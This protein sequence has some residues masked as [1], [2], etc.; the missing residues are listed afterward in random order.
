MTDQLASAEATQNPH[1]YAIFVDGEPKEH[2]ADR[3]HY[4]RI[5]ELAGEAPDPSAKFI[6]L[7]F[8]GPPANPKGKMGPGESVEIKQGMRFNVT[9]TDRS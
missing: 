9:R 2:L 4:V 3:I 5:I 8:D 1:I 6:V 7:Y